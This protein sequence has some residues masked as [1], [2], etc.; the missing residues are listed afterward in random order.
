MPY[1]A[2]VHRPAGIKAKRHNPR[3]KD[4]ENRQQRRAM[5][6]GSKGWKLQRDRILCR[7]R[8]TCQ[9]PGCGCYGDQ[10]DHKHNNSHEHVPDEDLWVLC[11]NHHSAKTM[12]EMNET[13]RKT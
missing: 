1:R 9:W 13:R 2:P 4:A 6:T 12:R 5:H 11:I 3:G 10:V 7:D 8:F